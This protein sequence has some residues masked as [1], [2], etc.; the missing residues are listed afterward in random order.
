MSDPK[1][2]AMIQAI[3]DALMVEIK[4]QQLYAHAAETTQD[5][6]AKAMF[7]MLA[8]DEDDHVNILKTQHRSLMEDGCI[9]LDDVHPAEVDHGSQDVITDGFKKSIKR[10]QFEMAVISIGC[11][12]ENKAIAYY[13]EQAAKTDDPDLKQLFTWLVEWE[14]GHLEQLMELE[15]I[16]QDAYWADQGFSPM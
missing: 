15:K 6:A 5:P 1:K 4:G 12:L 10:G 8:K 9:N 13:K 11:D 16:Y 14:D 7:N 2:D 3:K